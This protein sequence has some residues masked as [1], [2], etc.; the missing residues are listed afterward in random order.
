MRAMRT[1]PISQKFQ[2]LKP[3]QFI[4]TERTRKRTGQLSHV[5][6]P[7]IQYLKISDKP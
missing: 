3:K 5:R 1:S 4:E 6:P 7:E 2:I